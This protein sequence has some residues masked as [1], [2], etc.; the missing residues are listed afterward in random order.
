MNTQTQIQAKNTSKYYFIAMGAYWLIF[1]LITAFYPKLMDMFQTQAGI[2]AKTA[3]SD[4]VWRHDGFDIAALAVILFTLSG[5]VVS[6]KT[7]MATAVAAL[8]VTVAIFSSLAT[9][10]YW[11]TM[12]I[13]AGLGCFA[14]VIWGFALATKAK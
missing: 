13:S 8:M 6:R 14:F 1:G 12:F 11:N 5:E 2:S 9:T 10:P 7:L 3:F 4:H